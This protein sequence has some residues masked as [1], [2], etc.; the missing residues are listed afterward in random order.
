MSRVFFRDHVRGVYLRRGFA[1]DPRRH[2][3]VRIPFRARA[4]LVRIH[5]PLPRAFASPRPHERDERA[6][7]IILARFTASN[8][9]RPSSRTSRARRSKSA[10]RRASPRS[11]AV[12]RSRRRVV[13]ASSRTVRS[14]RMHKFASSAGQYIRAAATSHAPHA[15]RISSGRGVT[16]R[17]GWARAFSVL[18][19]GRSPGAVRAVVRARRSKRAIAKTHETAARPLARRRRRRRRRR[20]QRVERAG[21]RE[22]LDDVGAFGAVEAATRARSDASSVGTR[23]RCARD[24][25]IGAS[26]RAIDG[27]HRAHL[28][29]ASIA[30]SS[31]RW[32]AS[33]RVSASPARAEVDTCVDMD[34]RAGL[35]RRS[36]SSA[37]RTARTIATAPRDARKMRARPP[38]RSNR[39]PRPSL[40]SPL[41]PSRALATHRDDPLALLRA[42]HRFDGGRARDGRGRP[43]RCRAPMTCSARRF[44]W[45][46]L[47]RRSPSRSRRSSVRSPRSIPRARSA[48]A[49]ARANTSASGTASRGSNRRRI[50]WLKI[51]DSG[52]NVPGATIPVEIRGVRPFRGFCFAPWTGTPGRRSGRSGRTSLGNEDDGDVSRVRDAHELARGRIRVDGDAVDRAAWITEG[53]RGAIRADSRGVVRR[54]STCRE[55]LSS[56]ATGTTTTWRSTSLGA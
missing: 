21:S 27:A 40:A 26:R 19:L 43:H 45:R 38:N 36:R 15:A 44:E 10:L 55:S 41:A 17:G 24:R 12:P 50:F 32:S 37:A 3:S 31:A 9:A 1:R 2:S 47:A 25:A 11:R 54:W 13:V 16:P 34:A 14:H 22:E 52:V 8:D 33:A 23:E 39:I 7:K 56:A 4:R 29:M 30:S 20:R 6:I 42:G 49:R 46:P 53:I 5:R 28:G 35:V 48:P 18:E 51:G